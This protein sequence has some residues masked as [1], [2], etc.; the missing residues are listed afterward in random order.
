MSKR[1]IGSML[2]IVLFLAGCSAATPTPP[3]YNTPQ[4]QIPVTAQ[5]AAQQSAPTGQPVA[6]TNLPVLK[7][8]VVHNLKDHPAIASIWQ[9]MVDEAPIYNA[10]ITDFDPAFDP[11]KQA[12]QIDDCIARKPDV[13]L[14]NAVDP[15]A[16]IA[17]LKKAKDAGIP[18][19]MHN[20]DTTEEGHQYSRGFIGVSS[21][22]EGYDMGK[23]MC[24]DLGG[25]G[26]IVLLNGKAGQTDAVNRKAGFEQAAKDCG[27]TWTVV[28]EQYADWD[29]NKGM[30]VMADILTKN[31]KI[32]GLFAFSDEM[33]LGAIESMKAAGRQKEIKVY[34]V[35]LYEKAAC[36][37][38][39][40]GDIAADA[41]QSSYIIGY[42]AVRFSYDVV[43]GR[44]IPAQ[45][46]APT[47]AVTKD[48][49]DK[50]C[51]APGWKP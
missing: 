35:G 21:L 43:H 12:A 3:V 16:V 28:A 14:V 37:A 34:G 39:K 10:Q 31:P 18:V 1:A 5:P 27:A 47:V 17:S 42:T 46:L 11:Q 6:A 22:E 32:D 4:A 29:R 41:Q 20:A 45:Y 51:V 8:C 30:T 50:Y 7:M 33:A 26:N 9:G 49:I 2:L 38:V 19:I 24:K 48:N 40:N 15:T 25:K 23:A 13:I 44:L 36:D